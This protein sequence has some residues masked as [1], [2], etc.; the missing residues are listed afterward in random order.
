M[1]TATA[2][3]A[4]TQQPTEKIEAMHY[5][6]TITN[7]GIVAKLPAVASKHIALECLVYWI[8]P[9]ISP[10]HVARLT[11]DGVAA[12]TG[13][14]TVRIEECDCPEPVLTKAALQQAMSGENAIG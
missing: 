13:I 5:H 3:E 1:S 10:I 8:G 7:V 14:G 9:R 11:E 4:N 6:A 2:E 12:G